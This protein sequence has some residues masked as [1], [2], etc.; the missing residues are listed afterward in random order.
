MR[1]ALRMYCGHIRVDAASAP[2]SDRVVLLASNHPNSFFD[3]LVIAAFLPYRMRFLAR[4]DAFR[5]PRAARI[6]RAL[7]MIPIYRISEGRAELKR[8]AE[9]FDQAHA[10]LVLG[11]SVLVFSEGISVNES[12]L[13]PLGKGTAR[14]AYRA[15]QE[16]GLAALVLPVWLRYDTFRRPFMDVSMATGKV[17]R[18]EEFGSATEATFLQEFN[19]ALRERLVASSELVDASFPPAKG[20]RIVTKALLLELALAGLILHAPW[21][22]LLRGFIRRSITDPVFFDSVLFGLL[23][24][25]YPLWL[26]ILV[27]IAVWAGMGAC[28]LLVLVAAPVLL[29]ALRGFCLR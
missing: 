9:S 18:A 27:G 8:T 28:S 13:R 3:A 10:E 26:L 22:F 15:W 23:F 11:G 20:S 2:P 29:V 5:D 1:V 14:I 6:L 19:S 21:Y 7:F 17:M 24:L 4:G 16:A 25:T 12:S